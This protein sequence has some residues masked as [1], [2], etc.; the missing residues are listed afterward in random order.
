MFKFFNARRRYAFFL[1]FFLSFYIV[2]ISVTTFSLYSDRVNDDKKWVANI[3][4]TD[5]IQDYIDNYSG[6]AAR[7]TSGTY[8]ENIEE[9]SLKSSYYTINFIAWFSW[10]GHDDIDI[11]NNVRIYKGEISNKQLLKDYHKDGQNYQR[12]RVTAKVSKNYATTR[13]P[14]ESHQFRMYI[15]TSYPIEEVVFTADRENSG[16]NSSM[17]ITGYEFLRSEVGSFAHIYDKTWSDPEISGRLIHSEVV[18][19]LEVNRADFGLYIKCIIAMLGTSV[20]VF[21]VMFIN[22]RHRVDPLSMIPAALFGTVS[23][24]MVG[25]N[26]LPDALSLGL[27]EYINI[28]GIITILFGALSIINVNRIRAKASGGS[29]SYAQLFGRTMFYVLLICTIAGHILLPLAAYRF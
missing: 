9:I 2:F 25:A 19:D 22:V 13:F 5:E 15:E 21:I 1:C 27:I 7:I 18:T 28:F 23:N 14:L 3:N 6:D 12:I 24:I 26:L 8:V 10:E 17:S 16:L 29:E 4:V 11:A 20:W